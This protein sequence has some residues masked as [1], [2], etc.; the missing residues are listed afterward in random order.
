M[1]GPSA[2][3]LV[4]LVQ[5]ARVTIPRP[6]MD[7][8]MADYLAL[9]NKAADF[10]EAGFL[11]GWAIMAAQRACKLNGLWVRLLKRDGKPG[12][13]RHMPRTLWHLSVAFEHPI[14]APLRNWCA[15]AGIELP[16]SAA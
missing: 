11:K 7:Q 15:E 14:L 8:L 16:E 10:D 9:R 12:Y 2:Y 3:D 5:D 4:S 6:L 13:M 1:I